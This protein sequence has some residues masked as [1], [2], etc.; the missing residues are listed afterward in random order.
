[1]NNFLTGVL[2][3]HEREDNGEW[4]WVSKE[5]SLQKPTTCGDCMTYFKYLENQIVIEAIDRKDLRAKTGSFIYNE[6]ARFRQFYDELIESLKTIQPLP[7]ER[8]IYKDYNES[9]AG[10]LS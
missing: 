4:E 8:E 6:G 9:V 3:G 1:M 7:E 5:P 10:I 2:W